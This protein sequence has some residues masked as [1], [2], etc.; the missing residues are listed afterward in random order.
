MI[1]SGVVPQDDGWNG[2]LGRYQR[3]LREAAITLERQRLVK[4]AE[5]NKNRDRGRQA[6]RRSHGPKEPDSVP[7]ETAK[8]NSTEP[9]APKPTLCRPR[10]QSH[11][12][13]DTPPARF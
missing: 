12:S 3:A 1:R 4:V 7:I 5:R 11:G 8:L 2:W 13:Q 10:R 6:D 9:G